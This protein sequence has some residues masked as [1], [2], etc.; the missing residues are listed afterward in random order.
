MGK[1]KDYQLSLQPNEQNRTTLLPGL[2]NR[3]ARDYV[4]ESTLAKLAQFR[5]LNL[6]VIPSSEVVGVF[7]STAYDDAVK[8]FLFAISFNS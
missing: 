1:I 8:I 7:K 5:F 6:M 2:M 3:T 4:I